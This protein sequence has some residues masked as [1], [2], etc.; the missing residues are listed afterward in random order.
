MKSILSIQL[1]CYIPY[2]IRPIVFIPLA[3]HFKSLLEKDM[4]K[5]KMDRAMGG[6]ISW[7]I[8][9]PRSTDSTDPGAKGRG[10]G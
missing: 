10:R 4:A 2:G 7:W 3:S 9:G 6:G 1:N 5:E 8:D